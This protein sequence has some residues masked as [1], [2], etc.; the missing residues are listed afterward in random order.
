MNGESAS[1]AGNDRP[2]QQ[3]FEQG[4]MRALELA[5]IT[6]LTLQK[7]VSA[8]QFSEALGANI[9]NWNEATLDMTVSDEYREGVESSARWLQAVLLAASRG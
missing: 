1:S 6:L 5:V 3:T 7:D 8:E 2:H 4:R 9:G